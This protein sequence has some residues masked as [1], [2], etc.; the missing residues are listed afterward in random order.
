MPEST[1]AEVASAI[2]TVIPKDVIGLVG[3]VML[4]VFGL[5]AYMIYQTSKQME[6]LTEAVRSIPAQIDSAVDE[7]KTV[8]IQVLT[9]K[10]VG[11]GGGSSGQ[12]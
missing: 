2:S 6:K 11:D 7:I 10:L 8:L 3:F 1:A 12:T 4:M 5:M 9:S